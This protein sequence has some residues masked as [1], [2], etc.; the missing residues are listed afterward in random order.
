M[1]IIN[2]NGAITIV[3]NISAKAVEIVPT[4]VV[5]DALGNK[6]EVKGAT[7]YLNGEFTPEAQL[8]YRIYCNT[9]IG[10]KLSLTWPASKNNMEC[11]KRVAKTV[12]KYEMEWADVLN[13]AAETAEAEAQLLKQA[14]EEAC[15]GLTDIEECTITTF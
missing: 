2:A 4:K 1:K 12:L 13:S 15:D 6:R 11:A 5:T 8:D 9:T 14:Y 10:G 7:C 3:T